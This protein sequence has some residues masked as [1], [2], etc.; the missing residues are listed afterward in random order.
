MAVTF[1]PP[2]AIVD[3]TVDAF[4]LTFESIMAVAAV[5]V[6]ALVVTVFATFAGARNYVRTVTLSDISQYLALQNPKLIWFVF[7]V[8]F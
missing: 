3:V 2:V 6:D 8:A 1:K 7:L 4:P 5:T